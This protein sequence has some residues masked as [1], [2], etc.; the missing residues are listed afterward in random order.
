MENEKQEP[1]PSPFM[2]NPIIIDPK[3]FPIEA[4]Q[5]LLTTLSSQKAF[6]VYGRDMGPCKNCG[7]DTCF[8]SRGGILKKGYDK[9]RVF[10]EVV[11]AL[12][13][14]DKEIDEAIELYKKVVNNHLK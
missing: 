4:I 12:N 8:N 14:S 6:V 9:G 5:D 10:I 2:G 3:Y 13:I 1:T 11:K 7:K